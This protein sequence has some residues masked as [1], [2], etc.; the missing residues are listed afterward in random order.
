MGSKNNRNRNTAAKVTTQKIPEKNDLNS[1]VGVTTPTISSKD[2]PSFPSDTDR[3]VEGV[4]RTIT[5]EE[6]RQDSDLQLEQRYKRLNQRLQFVSLLVAIL[7]IGLT[8][9]NVKVQSSNGNLQ[10][11]NN[12]LL[13]SQS[14]FEKNQRVVE[15]AISLGNYWEERLDENT[16]HK[17]HR[18]ILVLSS[19]TSSPEREKAFLS[20]FLDSK[21]YLNSDS[22]KKNPDLNHL[23]DPAYNLDNT[24]GSLPNLSV[25]ISRYRSALVKLLNTMEMIAIVHKHTKEPEARNVLKYAYVSSI[26]QRYE[27]LKPFIKAYQEKYKG[28]REVPAWQLLDEMVN[29]LNN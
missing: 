4:E 21:N 25:E 12:R 26:K 6:V 2:K 15:M 9:W 22:I 19:L 24:N 28:D 8:Y 14:E 1:N 27:A 16:R 17:A 10:E 29:E 11:L 13:L 7:A 20:D 18:F 5:V 23:L 3:V